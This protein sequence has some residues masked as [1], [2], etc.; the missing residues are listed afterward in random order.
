VDGLR[1]QL[2]AGTRLTL[3]HGGRVAGGDGLDEIVERGHQRIGAHQ[4]AVAVPA[5]GPAAVAAEHREVADQDQDAGAAGGIGPGMGMGL[6]GAEVALGAEHAGQRAGRAAGD[7]RGPEQVAD[8][9][10]EAEDFAP[11]TPARG[12]RG[13]AGDPAGGGIVQYHPALGVDGHH[14]VVGRGEPCLEDPRVHRVHG[15]SMGEECPANMRV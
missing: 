8:G 1:H 6:G 13:Q 11:G 12:R 9:A 2:L 10:V 4:A 7:A 15:R 3:D 5:A 14:A